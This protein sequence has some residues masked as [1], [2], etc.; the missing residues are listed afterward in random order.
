MKIE[1]LSTRLALSVVFGL[2][3]T[4]VLFSLCDRALV[5]LLCTSPAAQVLLFAATALG[6]I[7]SY[8]IRF[9]SGR[10]VRY[11]PRFT[12]LRECGQDKALEKI[13]QDTL[14]AWAVVFVLAVFNWWAGW[15]YDVPLGFL[16]LV[17]LT[18][19]VASFQL[20]LSGYFFCRLLAALSSR[21]R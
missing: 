3:C 5:D 16:A 10:L 7:L 13:H 4:S 19:F 17:V 8:L 1:N 11:H 14:V 21:S 6:G 9:H 20:A 18:G 2:C 15:F 12:L